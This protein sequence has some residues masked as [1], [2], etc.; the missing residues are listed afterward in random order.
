MLVTQADLSRAADVSRK[1]ITQWKR[2][3]SVVMQGDLV[4]VEK[5]LAAFRMYHRDGEERAEQVTAALAADETLVT[6]NAKT[7][8]GDKPPPTKSGKVTAD[9]EDPYPHRDHLTDPYDRAAVALLPS[10]A[11]R[12]GAVAALA[13]FEMGLPAKTAEKLRTQVAC[14]AMEL[15]CTILDECSVHPPPGEMDWGGVALFDPDKVATVDWAK[16]NAG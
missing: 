1:T 16:V 14:S 7:V 4:D 2:R 5:T 9:A 3:G 10:T 6:G 8:T 15:V 12:I 11:Y 13:A